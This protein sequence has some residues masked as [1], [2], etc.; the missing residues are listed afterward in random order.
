MASRSKLLRAGCAA[1][2]IV[3]LAGCG[4]M[5]TSGSTTAFEAA[6]SGAQEVPP[7]STGGSG[8]AQVQLNA[9][10]QTLS[11][12]ITHSGLSGPVVAG[13]I[14]GPAPSGQ[15]AGVLIPF[16]GNLNTQPITGQAQVTAAQA[17]A[18]MAGQTYVN[19]HTQRYPG[20]EVRGQLTR[21]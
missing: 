7:V 9:D 14:H 20:G 3:S 1:L 13:H 8:R 17:Q 5:R 12:T 2:V 16:S 18:L 6:L 4:M 21:R 11:W 15:N 10:N 19:L